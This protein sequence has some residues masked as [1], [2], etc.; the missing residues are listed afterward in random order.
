MTEHL[1]KVRREVAEARV[2]ELEAI[3]TRLREALKDAAQQ[4]WHQG[5]VATARRVEAALEET[6]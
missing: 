3:N 4:L 2:L 1:G 5:L 6:K